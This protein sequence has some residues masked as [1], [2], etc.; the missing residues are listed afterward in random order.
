[1]VNKRP[2]PQGAVF[3]GRINP[4]VDP[5]QLEIITMETFRPEEISRE[6]IEQASPKNSGT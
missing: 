6:S 1:M 5:E 4:R 2:L 3:S